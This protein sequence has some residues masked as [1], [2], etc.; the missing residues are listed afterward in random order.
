MI[1]LLKGPDE[2]SENELKGDGLSGSDCMVFNCYRPRMREGN[3][4]VLFV[5]LFE[6]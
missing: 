4:F 6:L 5:C 2:L 3:V 1:M